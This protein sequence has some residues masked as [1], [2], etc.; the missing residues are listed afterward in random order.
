MLCKVSCGAEVRM[1]IWS[2]AHIPALGCALAAFIECASAHSTA[3]VPQ[4]L[5]AT[6][7]EQLI[8]AC[9]LVLSLPY[10]VA[11]LFVV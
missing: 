4:R 6:R 9:S 1:H 11:R 8:C 5:A 10:V 3:G 2:V 7:G